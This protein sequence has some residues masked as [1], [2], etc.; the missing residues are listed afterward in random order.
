[1]TNKIQHSSLWVV[2]QFYLIKKLAYQDYIYKKKK[3][4]KKKKKR[5]RRRRR[6]K[7]E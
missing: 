1:L 5:R 2:T 7:K 6:K 3:K 4:K